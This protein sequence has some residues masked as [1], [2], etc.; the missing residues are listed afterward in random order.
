MA[1]GI[2]SADSMDPRFAGSYASRSSRIITLRGDAPSAPFAASSSPFSAAW[3]ACSFRSP[4]AD[5][6][7]AARSCATSP[8]AP[9]SLLGPLSQASC[10][11]AAF[12]TMTSG[13]SRTSRD[14][15]A[16]QS[17]G[18]SFG[19]PA[20]G[21]SPLMRFSVCSRD[22]LF[23]ARTSSSASSAMP[24]IGVRSPS[25]TCPYSRRASRNRA[26]VT[27]ELGENNSGSSA[28]IFSRD[29]L[30][31]ASAASSGSGDPASP[32]RPSPSQF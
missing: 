13:P 24:S 21:A 7:V 14:D 17:V 28:S 15:C 3:G 19:S 32:V 22:C 12:S 16:S 5:T 25:H 26:A 8:A 27:G 29:L 4:S 31:S 20:S 1:T 30:A 18:A 23:P 11:E 9:A 6:S 10:R 2:R